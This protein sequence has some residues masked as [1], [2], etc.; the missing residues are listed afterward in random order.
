MNSHTVSDLVSE[1]QTLN[2]SRYSLPPD[3]L[4]SLGSDLSLWGARKAALTAALC[5]LNG[6]TNG[7][8]VTLN[9]PPIEA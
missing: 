4:V 9:C 3:G 5:M 8:P 1:S 6:A 2:V 7:I